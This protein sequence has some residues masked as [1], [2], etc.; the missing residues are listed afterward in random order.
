MTKSLKMK[1]DDS[2]GQHGGGAKL[3]KL[4]RSLIVVKDSI[5]LIQWS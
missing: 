4:P 3:F 1:A 5:Y 2:G